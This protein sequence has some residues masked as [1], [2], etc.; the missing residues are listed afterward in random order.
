MAEACIYLMQ[1]VSNSDIKSLSQNTGTEN[2]FLHLNI[3]TGKDLRISELAEV[4][5][6]IIG[7]TGEIAWDSSKPDGTA[8][9]LLDVSRINSL[10]WK[11]SIDLEEGIK[12]VY[13]KY[14]N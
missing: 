8:R 5:K 6:S 13:S 10:G 3:G 2:R 4:I 1:N 11:E 9:K 12:M 7:F 14:K